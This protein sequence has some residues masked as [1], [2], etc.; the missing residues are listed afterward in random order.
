MTMRRVEIALWMLAIAMT[1]A[2][3]LRARQGPLQSY[4]EPA[5]RGVALDLA[6]SSADSVSNVAVRIVARDPFRL[7]R[8]PAEV[9][10]RPDMEGVPATPAAPTPP[11]PMLTLGGITGGP[12]WEALLDG[13]PGADHTQLAHAGSTFGDLRVRRVTRD[14]VVVAGMDT[15]WILTLRKDWP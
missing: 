11:K 5:S 9:V 8:V 2:A 6:G 15:V 14:T 13:I 3:A 10:Y 7:Q 1:G 12:P 4:A